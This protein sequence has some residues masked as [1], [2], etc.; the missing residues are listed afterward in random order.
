MKTWKDNMSEYSYDLEIEEDFSQHAMKTNIIK[1]EIHKL[2][3]IH[4]LSRKNFLILF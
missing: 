4:F 1:K 2:R 3:H